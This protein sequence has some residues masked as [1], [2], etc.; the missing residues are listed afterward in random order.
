MPRWKRKRGDISDLGGDRFIPK[1]RGNFEAARYKLLTKSQDQENESPTNTSQYE[2]ELSDAMFQ[3]RINQEKILALSTKPPKATTWDNS[4]LRVLYSQ[5]QMGTISRVK[6]VH[7]NIPLVPLHILDAPALT[8][9]FYLNLLD[10]SSLNILAIALRERVFCWNPADM[11]VKQVVDLGQSNDNYVASVSWIKDGS[12]LAVGDSHNQVAIYDVAKSKKIRTMDGHESRVGSLSWNNHILS[13]G[14]RDGL[15]INHDVRVKEHITQVL[16][17]HNQEIC[18]LR[19][20]PDGTQ[21]SSGGNDNIVNIWDSGETTPRFTFTEHNAAVKAMSW[22]PWHRNLLVTGGGTADGK[23]MFWNTRSGDLMNSIDTKSQVSSIFWS[24]IDR[25][26]VS[27]HGFSQNQLCVW[28][29]P[30]LVKVADLMGHSARVLHMAQSPDGTTICSAGA[31]ETLRLWNI[32]TPKDETKK[33][34]KHSLSLRN[35]SIR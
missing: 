16:K 1:R 10:W 19:W 31:D 33:V 14:G 24:E 30:S 3:S 7:R 32:F 15:I 17:G 13:S 21:L 22:C 11:S 4:H 26:L 5:N 34:E 29:Y 20:S 9:D 23:M 2:N 25:E 8:N 12:Y 6:P 35:M 28:K 27:G 18:G